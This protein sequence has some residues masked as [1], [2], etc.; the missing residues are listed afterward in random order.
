AI[1][2]FFIYT[3]THEAAKFTGVI[4]DDFTSEFDPF[5]P[6]FGEKFSPPNMP[7]AFRDYTG[8]EISRVYSDQ[9]G[10]FNGMT[11]SSWEVNPPNPTGYSPTMMIT[12][13]N[14]PGPV[15]GPNGT[16][17]TDPL[18]NP[19]Y[20]QFCYEIP[21]MPGQTQYMDT[22]VVP[23]AAFAGSGYNNVDCSYPDATPA[24]KEVDG[25]GIGPWVKESGNLLTIHA[26]GD[27]IVN[28]YGYSGPAAT[29][30]PFNQK[31]VTR[32]YGFGGSQGSGWVRIGGV[33]APVQSWSD[34]TI[35]VQVPDDV[36]KCA[37]QQQEQYGGKEAHCGELVIRAGNGK[38]SIDSV[39][40]T[41]GGKAPT[42]LTASDPLT[43]TGPGAIQRAI[44]AALPGDLIIVPPGY[45]NEMLIMWKPVRLQGVGAA[46]SI[47]NANAQPAGK[48]DP[49]RHEVNCLFGLALNGTPMGPGH[50]Y[51]ATGAVKCAQEG[52]VAGINGF[53]G[54][55]QNPQID[56]LP[57]EGIVGWDTTTNG[58]LAQMLQEP[59]LMGAYEGA[60]ITVLA[61]GVNTHGAKSGYYG[62]GAEAAFPTGS[63]VLTKADCTSGRN[64]SN[65]Y[66]SNFQCNPSSIDG[67]AITDS[68]EGGGGI[69]VHA[70]AHNL[71]I[72][73]NRIYN[74]I[75]TLAGGINVGQGESPDGYFAGTPT[76]SDPGSCQSSKITNTQLPYCFDMHLN[77][78]NN[79][80]TLNTSIGDELFSGTPA[81]AGGV[82]FCT[83]ADYYKFNYNWVCGNESTGDGGGVSHLGFIYHGTISHNTV[84]FNLSTNP[85]I[86][87]NGGGII[88]EGAA[89]DG[90]TTAG[91]ECGS[92]VDI[93]CPPGLPDGT[94]PGLRINANLIMGNSAE[95]G[96]GGGIRFQS[97]TGPEVSVF[98]KHP[99]RWYTVAVTNNII[100]NNV[101]GWDGGGVSLQDSLAVN[102]VNNT[103]V[104]NDS[105]ASSGVLFN[106]LGAPLASAPGA[107]NQTFTATTSAPQPAGLV[108]MQNSG[109]LSATFKGLTITCPDA[110]PNCTQISTPYLTNNI[111]WQNRTYYIGVG[112]LDA[113]YQQ[114]IVAIYNSAFSAAGTP[115][116]GTPTK[117]QA[118]TGSCPDNS[119]YWDLGVRGDSGPGNHASGYTLNANYSVLTNASE[120]NGD[121]NLVPTTVGVV[122]QYCNGSR[123]PPEAG[124]T[125]GWQVPPG[126]ADA[127]VPNPIFSLTPNATV[128]EGNNWVNISW[129]PL[130]LVNPATQV[131]LGD[132]ALTA[133]SPAVN[134]IPTNTD[135]GK[136]APRRDFFGNRR[137]DQTDQTAIDVGAVEYTPGTQ[138]PMVP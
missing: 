84:L 90:F 97:V 6:A 134:F 73:N 80:V 43:P 14:D 45:Y 76:D 37:V 39:T 103:I 67:L 55:T 13:M 58:N 132:Y 44:D 35:V 118:A 93:D 19:D 137:P 122:S 8:A 3:S 78:H 81:G 10:A 4:T 62:S 92:V 65:P 2:K 130:A 111:L 61:K 123:T 68:S 56:R 66:P 15:P 85:T 136:A 32:H 48:L 23:T 57:L 47:I 49:W 22:P 96:S 125:A 69:F 52:P 70:W 131:A 79:D 119:T 74:N 11:Y 88:I 31:T 89:P 28:N 133:T 27:Q 30:A 9:W 64:D 40:V 101:A 16:T 113:N 51:D 63:T 82:S 38:K 121:H 94:G 98:P 5:S 110:H 91:L 18:F 117:N 41:I 21:F 54:K 104:A 26:L 59:T 124:M 12:C 99:E 112:S 108:S 20:S 36:P 86:A 127:Q 60:G 34:T 33:L 107:T 135:A 24:I 100:A 71:Q 29:Q 126:I 1:A 106:T 83:G 46:S 102:F 77:V 25:D 7:I 128:D 109:N 42:V 72:A 53:S 87:T 105:T 75:G 114:N 138:P 116:P 120:N 17:I 129:G 50:P 95:S 115:Q